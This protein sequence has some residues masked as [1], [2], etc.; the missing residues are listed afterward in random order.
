[1]TLMASFDPDRRVVDLSNGRQAPLT[2]EFIVHPCAMTNTHDIEGCLLDIEQTPDGD[3]RLWALRADGRPFLLC[4]ADFKNFFYVPVQDPHAADVWLSGAVAALQALTPPGSTEVTLVEKR[5]LVYIRPGRPSLVPMLRVRY[6][7]SHKEKDVWACVKESLAHLVADAG[8]L[9]KREKGVTA[10]HRFL[11]ESS[12]SGGAWFHARAHLFARRGSDGARVEC[13]EY[14]CGFDDM[15]GHAPEIIAPEQEGDDEQRYAALPPAKT[16]ALRVLGAAGEEEP[17]YPLEDAVRAVALV[18]A[19]PGAAARC[20]TVVLV[21]P[22]EEEEGA[23]AAPPPSKKAKKKKKPSVP[24]FGAVPPTAAS[25]LT[26]PTADGMVEQVRSTRV[27]HYCQTCPTREQRP[28]TS[29]SHCHRTHLSHTR[30]TAN[31][32]TLILPPHKPLAARLRERAR[33]ATRTRGVGRG[34]VRPRCAHHL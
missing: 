17:Q 16:L 12:L 21:A 18:A 22:L 4:I 5:E 8:V 28:I 11:A 23:A 13:D 32:V 31:H 33:S 3:M 25:T 2:A 15:I 26:R 9:V 6:A 19:A 30:A 24:A 27:A 7:L 20:I 14:T 34:R 29:P 10:T 1:M